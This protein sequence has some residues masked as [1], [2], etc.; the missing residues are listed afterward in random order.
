MF[1]SSDLSPH[2]CLG[3]FALVADPIAVI[4]VPLAAWWRSRTF[5]IALLLPPG[6]LTATLGVGLGSAILWMKKVIRGF[7]RSHSG[8]GTPEQSGDPSGPPCSA[9][10]F[11]PPLHWVSGCVALLLVSLEGLSQAP[12]KR[13]CTEPADQ[14]AQQ[15]L[16]WGQVLSSIFLQLGN[17][18]WMTSLQRVPPGPTC[19]GSPPSQEKTT[20]LPVRGNHIGNIIFDC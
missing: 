3:G 6:T 14:L 20:L 10:P 4:L 12:V 1:R 11:P 16:G 8:R 2:C 5:K 17:L 7:P 13:F 9:G 15:R 18:S 19:P